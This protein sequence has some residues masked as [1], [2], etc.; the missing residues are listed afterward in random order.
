MM[1]I[2]PLPLDLKLIS[3]TSH[4]DNR[5]EVME[6]WRNEWLPERQFVQEN[7][8]VS[9]HGV[10]RGLHFQRKNPQGKL[11]SVLSGKICDIALDIRPNSA[12]FGTYHRQ[13]L[14]SQTPQ[15]LWIP[16]DFAHGFSVLSEEAVVLYKMTDYYQ[17]Q[18]QA[19][20]RWDDEQLN[21]DWGITTPI[22]SDKDQNGINW[23]DY[24]KCVF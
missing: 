24:Q 3:L 23:K 14:D 19:T 21:I 2:K 17:P 5:G 6:L 13:I 12:T 11:I 7:I 1:N 18:D 16:P 4:A 9:H 15:L 8:S 20:I 10:I 22:V